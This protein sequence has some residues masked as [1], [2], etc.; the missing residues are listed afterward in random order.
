[1]TTV[2]ER[3]AL[4]PDQVARKLQIRPSTVYKYIR[5]G[6]LPAVR[7]GRSYRILPESL[8]LFLAIRRTSRISTDELVKRVLAIAERNRH[9]PEEEVGRDVAEAVAQSRRRS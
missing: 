5:N 8:E 3:P 9:I 6:S 7:L 2:T 4:T 1:M